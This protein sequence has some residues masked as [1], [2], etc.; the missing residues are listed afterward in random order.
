[1]NTYSPEERVQFLEVLKK[2]DV[3]DID[4]AA[5]YPDSEK[6]IGALGAPKDFV[7]HTKVKG[8]SPGS[9]KRVPLVSS[10]LLSLFD[11]KTEQVDVLFLH[12]PDAETPLTETL[13]AVQEVYDA[14]K[15]KRFGLSN[16]LPEQVQEAHDICK[17]KG[18]VLPS[19]Y[20]GNYNPAS[21]R[22]EKTLFPL[23]RKLKMCFFAYS[24]LAGGFLTKT[25]EAVSAG[26]TGGRFDKESRIGQMYHGLYSKPSLLSAL[27]RWEAIAK[28]AG[29]SRAALAYRWVTYHS[30]LNKEAGDGIILGASRPSQLEETL[31][32]IEEGPLPEATAKAIEEWWDLVKDEVCV[33]LVS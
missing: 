19:V 20:Q 5:G 24:P 7:I 25:K 3:K 21:R 33:T 17:S 1:M 6:I 23:L 31:L 28:D 16:F 8:F 11:L 18:Y 12:S 4:T 15:F 13:A 30:A 26:I 32:S 10:A 14:G 22:V 27:E 29:V 9:L 2:Y